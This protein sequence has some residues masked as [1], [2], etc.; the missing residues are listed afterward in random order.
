MELTGLIG[1]AI[2]LALTVLVAFPLAGPLRSHPAPFYAVAIAASLAYAWAIAAGVDLS[3]VRW[4]TVVMQKGYL[5]VLLLAVVMFT[6]VLD[7][8]SPARR[9]LQ[10]IRG[11]LSI[12]SFLLVLGHVVT[13]LPPYLPRLGLLLASRT[14]VALSLLVALVL[15]TL[16]AVLTLTSLR[17]VRRR[18]NPRAWRA[19]QR[20]SYLMVALLALHV[21]L[22]LGRSAGSS[23]LAATS[24]ATYLVAI[25]AYAMLRVRKAL[26]SRAR[27][28]G[29]GTVGA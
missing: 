15:V 2:A 22:A 18:M 20:G 21:A 5:A 10:P 13:Y 25:A 7:E 9:R 3:G 12:L 17:A 19:L 16:F 26:R 28:S 27:E 1:F 4:L 29:R 6:G 23:A 24:L 14:N 11:E 8:G